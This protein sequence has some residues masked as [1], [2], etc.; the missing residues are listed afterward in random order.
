MVYGGFNFLEITETDRGADDGDDALFGKEV[1][2]H[3]ES[4][5]SDIK[6]AGNCIAADLNTAAVFHL[7]RV[8]EIGLHALAYELGATT[9]GKKNT[10]I[11]FRMWGEIIGHIQSKMDSL[12]QG[13]PESEKREKSQFYHGLLIECEAIKELLRNPVSHGG[14]RYNEGETMNVFIHVKGFMT[15]LAAKIQER[16]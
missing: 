4:A 9:V 8:T 12:T 14:N 6:D 10:P 15:R 13:L 7:M 3:F 2:E 11:E 5:R 1:Y 16:P